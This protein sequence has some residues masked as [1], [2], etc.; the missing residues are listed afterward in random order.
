MRLPVPS[1]P[2]PEDSLH[3][4]SKSSLCQTLA[5]AFS[6]SAI[7]SPQAGYLSKVT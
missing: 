6:L 5:Q 4:G 7:L 1:S 3:A 2:F